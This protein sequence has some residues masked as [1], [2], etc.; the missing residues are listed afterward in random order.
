MSLIGAYR[1]SGI[2]LH[3]SVDP[4][5]LVSK[6]MKHALNMKDG[7]ATVRTHCERRAITQDDRGNRWLLVSFDFG[8]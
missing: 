8:H 3:D 5:R 1:A 6:A 2:R 4:A 7:A